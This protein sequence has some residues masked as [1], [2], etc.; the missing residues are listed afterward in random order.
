MLAAPTQIALATDSPGAPTIASDQ[1]DYAPGDLVTLTGMNW[2]PGESVHIFVNDDAGITWSRNADVVA[3][4][5]GGIVDQF[6]L[7]NWF[8]ATYSVT[9]TGQLSGVATTTFTDA[10]IRFLSSGPTL[11]AVAW[12]R[13]SNSA[14][15]TPISGSTNSGSGNITTV[16]SNGGTLT[17]S[18][19]VNQWLGL[20]APASA[21]GQS[22]VSWTGTSGNPSFSVSGPG[23]RTVCVAGD[24]SNGLRRLTANYAATAANTTTSAS[25]ASAGY[26]DA[27]VTLSATIAPNTVG[28]GTVTFTVKSGST[29]IGT[30]TS[31]PVSGG[32]ATA[33]FSLAGVNAGTYTIEA[34][35]SGGTGFNA[36]NNSGQ[37]PAPSLTIGQASSTTVVTCPAGPYTYTG[38]AQT[39][40]SVSVTGANLSLT[41]TPDYTGNTDAG[42]ATASYTYAGDANHTGSNDSDTFEIDPLHIT[43]SFTAANKVYDGGTSAT[44][45]SRSLSGAVTGDDV[46]LD[47]GTATFSDKNVGNGKTVTLTGAGLSGDDAGNYVLDSVST[48]TAKIWA[49]ALTVSGITANDKPWDG[50]PSAGLNLAG[51]S[52]VGVISGD[53]VSLSTAGATGTF[54]SSA[55]GTWS[56]QVSGL[57]ISGSDAGNYS[58]TQ[59]TTTASILAWNAQGYG[60]YQPV[61]VPNSVFVAAPG[62]VPAPQL[63]TVWNTSKG[64]STI[65]LKFNIYGGTVEQTSL[66]AIS[67]FTVY[68]LTCPGASTITEDAVEFVTTGNTNLRYDTTAQQWIQNWQTPKAGQDTCY[69]ATVKFADGSSL[70]AFF[71]L[72]K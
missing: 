72:K 43:G 22:F 44:V 56:V 54:S 62:P 26:G 60:F 10:D 21:S 31:G 67:N 27:S 71:K 64:G 2:A 52:L 19:D 25:N 50:N 4:A 17:L 30:A 49:K 13:Y 18:A 65:P 55:V 14:C 57:S 16:D 7:P 23:N 33:S 63:S 35:Y 48:T 41:P 15:T 12:Q 39:P 51:A 32:S 6:N 59:P 68:K 58:L 40:C 8:V 46:A 42:T 1:A 5:S 34:A 53:S 9:A 70:S 28:V 3:D 47:G 45:T 69:R 24:G 38:S 20:T 36:S 66:E 29:T 11:S 61:G 37:S